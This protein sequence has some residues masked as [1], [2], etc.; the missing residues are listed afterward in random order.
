MHP[1]RMRFKAPQIFGPTPAETTPI[2]KSSAQ[3][4][5]ASGR[6][7][8]DGDPLTEGLLRQRQTEVII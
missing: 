7:H 3:P 8:P 6:V 4:S 2:R 1:S 5:L